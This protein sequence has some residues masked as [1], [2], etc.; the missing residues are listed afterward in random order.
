MNRRMNRP[1]P[2]RTGFTLI[3]LLVVIAI[4]GALAAILLPAVQNAREAARRS[5]CLN[6]LKQIILACHNYH[7]AHK[8]FPSGIIT[9]GTG[10]TALTLPEPALIPLGTATSAGPPPS[11]TIT[12]WDYSDD[13]GWAAFILSQMGAGTANVNFLEPKSSAN[14]QSAAQ[15]VLSSYVCA[16]SSLPNG[17][18]ALG[19]T[20][21]GGAAYLTYRGNAGTS[22]PPGAG[23]GVPTV[24][25][26]FYRDSQVSFKDIARDGESNTIALGESM[27]GYWG[28]GLSGLARMADD[29]HNGQPDWGTDGTAPSGS[30]ST[31]D[32]YL[33][34]GSNHIFGFGS[35]HRDVVQFA[36]ADGSSRS[37]SKTTDFRIMRDMCTR[38]GGE[39]VNVPN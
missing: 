17:R 9:S 16:S 13:W 4:I 26:V 3:E 18:P 12:N 24:N 19:G 7:D 5:E 1:R 29:D 10:S 20:Q 11:V 8:S 37:F 36:L 23:A 28:D 15:V 6:N 31:F 32:T 14:N 38:D 33:N 30:P 39:R 27:M 21:L 25:G 34:A 2:E 22:P 35:W